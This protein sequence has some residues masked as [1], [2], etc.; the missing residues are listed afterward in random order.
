MQ[1]KLNFIQEIFC[2]SNLR[3]DFLARSIRNDFEAPH[4]FI[5][6]LYLARLWSGIPKDERGENIFTLGLAL[7][8]LKLGDII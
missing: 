6:R 3:H 8:K 2:S 1:Q 4:T 5:S 7:I